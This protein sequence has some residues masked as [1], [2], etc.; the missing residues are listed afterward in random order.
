MVERLKE[1]IERARRE[2][3]AAGG[4][5]AGGSAGGRPAAAPA[6][7]DP[8]GWLALPSLEIDHGRLDRERIITLDRNN[9]AYM[10]FDMLRTKLTGALKDSPR[11][12]IGVTSPTKGCGKSFVSLNLAFSLA[13]RAD[14]SVLLVDMDLRAPSLST[15]LG[16]R[17]GRRL[18]DWLSGATTTEEH[19]VRVGDNMALALNEHTVRDSAEVLQSRRTAETLAAADAALKPDLT[20]FDMPPMLV[21]DDVSA[22]APNIDGVLMVAQGGRTTAEQILECER[23]LPETLPMLGVLLNRAEEAQLSDYYNS[24]A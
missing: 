12:R 19:L 2:R 6:R 10:A 18:E 7:P 13:R 9:P 22:F 15:K 20:L 5:P 17:K 11:R 8:A 23:Q 3:E 21:C 24:Y 14:S 1:A 4:R 16:V